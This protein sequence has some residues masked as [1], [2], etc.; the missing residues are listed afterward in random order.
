VNG[1]ADYIVVGAGS[2]G[3]IVAAR[4]SEDPSCRVLLLE[5]GGSDRTR[6]C[7]V[8]GMVSIIHTTPLVKKRFDWGFH[9]APQARGAGRRMPYVRG[10][11]VGGSSAINGMVYVRGN[12]KN[13]DDWQ[14]EG[15]AGWGYTDAVRC[16]KRL[17]DWE[18]GADEHRGAGGPIAVTRSRDLVPASAALVEAIAETCEVP[19]LADYNG[20]SQ[21]GVGP[22][23]MNARDGRRYSTSEAYVHPAAVRPNFRL[24][25]GVL[26]A[27]VIFEGRRAVG[28][29]IVE[30][31]QRRVLRA[32]REVVLSAG[33]IGS[34]HL[35]LLSGVGP[36]DEL[37]AHG[38]EPIADL[39]VGKNLHDHL[40]VPM[41]FLAPTAVHRG[42]PWHFVGGMI[43]ESIKGGTWFSRTVF[44]VMG[45]V[46]SRRANGVPDLQIHCLP[47]AYPSPNQD[48]PVRPVVDTRPALTVMPTLIYPKSRGEV[49]LASSDPAAAPHIDPR[50]LQEPDDARHLLEGIDLVREIM[51]SRLLSGVVDGEL[52]PG[53]AFASREAMAAELPTRIHTV[54]HPVG[55][56]R[57]GVDER[58]VV[59]PALRVRGLEG[60]R[61]ADA[62]IMPTITGGNT[63]A[64]TMMIGERCAE[65]LVRASRP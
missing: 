44:D 54:Y 21:L 26:V 41:T 25:S 57:M 58:A 59:D 63:N 19:V 38:V 52:H 7:T 65:I 35:L 36:A 61:V 17:E 31:G 14:A 27:R 45:F 49:R 23:Q 29:E 48:R 5:A 51:A 12:R 32:E 53:P 9:T 11:V 64:P 20:A 10:K 15:C 6:L 40:F 37:R 47:W 8:P 16:Y 13:Y 42:T 3:G 55:T 22:C 30:D 62:S 46:K 50:F 60:L 39:P 56:C 43:A 2:A 33:V 24:L 18:G 4:L 28:V 34:A 1:E